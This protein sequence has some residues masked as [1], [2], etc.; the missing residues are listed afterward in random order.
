[1]EKFVCDMCGECCINLKGLKGD[2][3]MEKYKNI[4]QSVLRFL[5]GP[6]EISLPIREWEIPKLKELANDK[7]INLRIRPCTVMLS[8]DKGP[9]IVTWDFDHDI[10]PFLENNKCTIYENRPLICQSFPFYE[11]IGSFLRGEDRMQISHLKCHKMINYKEE[12]GEKHMQAIEWKKK[13]LEMFGD[14]FVGSV[15]SEVAMFMIDNYIEEIVK[16]GNIDRNQHPQ[17]T[18]IKK[19]QK[20]TITL[21]NYMLSNHFITKEDIDSFSDLI[22]K[23]A[24]PFI[25]E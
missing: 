13:M 10:C 11:T 1:M 15:K 25:E 19:C 4:K 21:F 16:S 8:Y 24:K 5:V 14:V 17:A 18:I 23:A 20:S 7:K 9:I 2:D 12:L 22:E 6:N 3:A